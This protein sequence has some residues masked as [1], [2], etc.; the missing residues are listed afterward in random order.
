MRVE[1]LVTDSDPER[2]CFLALGLTINMMD[3]D[4]APLNASPHPAAPARHV[5]DLRQLPLLSAHDLQ[6]QS[7]PTR[8][9]SCLCYVVVAVISAL[10]GSGSTA[11][12]LILADLSDG[13]DNCTAPQLPP[14]CPGLCVGRTLSGAFEANVSTSKRVLGVTVVVQF[15]IQHAFFSHNGSAQLNVVPLRFEPRWLPKMLHPQEAANE[16]SKSRQDETHS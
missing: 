3:D 8:C 9:C 15:Y 5:V 14:E 7:R 2:P 12:V 13:D 4:G 11:A 1:S 6:R 10:I 16:H